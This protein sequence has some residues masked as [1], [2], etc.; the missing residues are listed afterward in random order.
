MNAFDYLRADLDGASSEEIAEAEALLARLLDEST[1]AP[2]VPP[3]EDH[4]AAYEAALE[5]HAT[6]KKARKALAREQHPLHV[7]FD[8]ALQAAWKVKRKRAK[9][10]LVDGRP[11][12]EELQKKLG[13]VFDAIRTPLHE[14]AQAIEKEHDEAVRAAAAEVDRLAQFVQAAAAAPVLRGLLSETA[15][16]RGRT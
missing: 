5:R 15:D 4:R 6:A 3:V 13:D 2:A 14:R 1:P 7:E 16:L 12:Y 8:D 9:F 10:P 11:N